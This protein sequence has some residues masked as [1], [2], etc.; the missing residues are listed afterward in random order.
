MKKIYFPP[1]ASVFGTVVRR[2]ISHSSSWDP[3]ITFVAVRNVGWTWLLL[4]FW[5]VLFG[6]FVAALSLM[7][8]V[9]NVYMR[10]TAHIV[11]IVL[12]IQFYRRPSSTCRRASGRRGHHLPLRTPSVCNRWSLSCRRASSV[13]RADAR[14]RTGLVDHRSSG[15]LAGGAA[16]LT[17]RKR[18]LDLSEEL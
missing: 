3:R 6:A 11:A 15:R 12:Q 14:T 2:S 9:T 17:Y 4:V 1:Y 18:G 10:D 16:W 7:L 5:V 8:S 13:L